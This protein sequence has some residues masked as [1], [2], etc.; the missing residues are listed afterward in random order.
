LQSCRWASLLK[1]RRATSQVVDA[2]TAANEDA[3]VAEPD[4]FESPFSHVPRDDAGPNPIQEGPFTPGK[5]AATTPHGPFR[6]RQR[7]VVIALFA[8]VGLVMLITLVQALKG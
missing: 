1:E 5:L 7:F 8:A 3:V 6:R 4:E 2:P